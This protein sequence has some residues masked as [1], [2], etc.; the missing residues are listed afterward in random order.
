MELKYNRCDVFQGSEIISTYCS[1]TDFPRGSP[2]F[3]TF[4]LA[5]VSWLAVSATMQPNLLPF[6]ESSVFLVVGF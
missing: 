5:Y 6:D 4:S 1:S 2:F 3:V